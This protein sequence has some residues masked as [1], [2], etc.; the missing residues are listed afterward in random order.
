M[1][2]THDTLVCPGWV[3]G[4][5]WVKWSTNGLT[6]KYFLRIYP[7]SLPFDALM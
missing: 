1:I 5:E 7:Q 6:V 2:G 4:A 3:G